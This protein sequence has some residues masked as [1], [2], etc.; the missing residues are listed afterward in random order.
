MQIDKVQSNTNF[1]SIYKICEKVERN[2]KLLNEIEEIAKFSRGY[3]HTV[4][5]VPY[6]FIPTER[7][8]MTMMRL[9]A[10]KIDYG[11]HP[12]LY[13][14]FGRVINEA[15]IVSDRDAQVVAGMNFI[16]VA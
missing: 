12:D 3:V 1:N 9:G 4:S 10:Q 14:Y 13:N 15:G 8:A 7:D 6:M 5:G 11:Y 2:P 16:S